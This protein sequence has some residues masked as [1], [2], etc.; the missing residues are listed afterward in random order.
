MVTGSRPGRISVVGRNERDFLTDTRPVE[1]RSD[2]SAAMAGDEDALR[3]VWSQ[4]RNWVAAILLA[5]KPRSVETDDLLQVVALK[6]VERLGDLRDERA[7]RPWL[8]TVAIN[9]ARAA[10]RRHQVEAKSKLRLIRDC[11]EDVDDGVDPQVLEQGRA[12]LE[13]ACELP[14]GYREPLL[15]R[16]VKGMSHREIAKVLELP[17]T[18]IETRIARGRRMLR[19]LASRKKEELVVDKAATCE[20]VVDG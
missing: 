13:M 17:E 10:G 6:M 9:A 7:F 20:G 19:E 14:D 8:R 2:V 4:N 12:L 15:L 3:R 5:H 1:G 16:C 11:D 18:T